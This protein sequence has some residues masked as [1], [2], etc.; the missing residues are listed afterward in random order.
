[1]IARPPDSSS[2]VPN[3]I[4][5]T[6]GVRLNTLTIAVPSWIFF[7]ASAS[8]VRMLNASRPHASATHDRLDAQV[9]GDLHALHE[10]FALRRAARESDL[11][12][13]FASSSV[14]AFR[15]VLLALGRL[16]HRMIMRATR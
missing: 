13:R 11:Q 9:L 16:Q 10:L 6:A 8:C 5:S 3:V 14:S 12:C 7:V 15:C 2:S 4:A 1:M